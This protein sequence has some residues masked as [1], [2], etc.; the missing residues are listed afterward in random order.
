MTVPAPERTDTPVKSRG[1]KPG[2]KAKE[3]AKIPAELFQFESVPADERNTVRRQ[4]GE[5]D[6]QQRRFDALIAAVRDEW[7]KLGKPDQWPLMPVKRLSAPAALVE[8]FQFYLRKAANYHNAK[9]IFGNISEKDK[10]GRK[11]PDNLTRIPFAVVDK[12]TEVEG[13]PE[14]N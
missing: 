10:N 13:A 2:Q 9:I 3:R 5:R 4:R 11:Y 6:E 7:R 1:R 14:Q 8:D 12:A